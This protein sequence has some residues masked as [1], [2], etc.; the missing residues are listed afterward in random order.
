MYKITKLYETKANTNGLNIGY[1]KTNAEMPPVVLGQ[2]YYFGSLRTT[3]VIGGAVREDGSVLFSTK[4]S[5][6]LIE[7]INEPI[8]T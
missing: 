5:T 8:S 3:P 2:D 6:Y 4:N 7:K 1:T